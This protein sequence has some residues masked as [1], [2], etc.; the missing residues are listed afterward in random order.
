MR[1]DAFNLHADPVRT[2]MTRTQHILIS[3][4]CCLEDSE[5]KGINADKTLLQVYSKNWS[6]SESVTV[7]ESYMEESK[8]GSFQKIINTNK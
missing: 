3:R 4:V 7:V 5:S 2:K 6:E 1:D 8:S